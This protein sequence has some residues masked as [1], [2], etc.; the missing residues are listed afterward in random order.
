[1]RVALHICCAICAAGAAERLIQEGHQVVGYFYNPNIYPPEEYRLRLENAR[2][3]AHELGF[4]L[5]E[6]P[7]EPE[8]WDA[9]VKGLENEPE[10]GQRCPLCFKMRLQKTHQV[11]LESG[12][13]AFASTLT[14]GSNKS[15]VLIEQLAREAGRETFISRD[16]KKKEGFKRAGELSRQW[17]LYRQNYCGCRYSLRDRDLRLKH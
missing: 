6:G 5:K 3:V 7:Y 8:V 13:E 16:F 14:M 9:L 11:M 1:M 4:E 2:K 12:C 10:G 15:A 17:G